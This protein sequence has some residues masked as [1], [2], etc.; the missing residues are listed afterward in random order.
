MILVDTSVWIDYFNGRDTR[1]TDR[2][3]AILGYEPIGIGD[4]IL[5]EVLQG[6]RSDEAYETAKTLLA[7]LTLFDMLGTAR[8]IEGA[9]QYRR[10]RKRGVT[11]RKTI[12]VIISTFCIAERH[13][14]LFSDRDFIPFVE[15]LGLQAAP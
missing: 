3:D 4:V 2:L 7:S 15:H 11:V 8:A 12:D 10:L 1:E 9:E 14:L 5:M 13:S 6:F